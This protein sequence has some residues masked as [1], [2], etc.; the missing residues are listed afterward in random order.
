MIAIKKILVPAD[1]TTLAVPAI[2][3]AVSLAKE[4][5]AEVMV[6]H[7]VPA[8][9][10]KQH[11]SQ[12][13]IPDG[14]L[15]PGGTHVPGRELETLTE[16][17][18]QSLQNFLLHKIAPDLLRAVKITPLIRFGKV[19]DEIIAAA[20]EEQCDLIV[21]TSHGS[22]L[23][24]LFGGSFTDRVVRHAPCPVLSIQPSAEVRTSENNRVPAKL[25]D[26]WAA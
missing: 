12:A 2:G 21:M 3:Y 15:S 10:L 14:V 20:R 4:H 16:T 24:H 7:A 5:H 8:E 18:K 11:F 19:V 26:K 1:L 22:G 17:K 6:L 9:V 13:Y 23:R 25:I